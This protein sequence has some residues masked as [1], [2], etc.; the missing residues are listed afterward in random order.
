ME[1]QANKIA[2]NK[3]QGSPGG[4]LAK[5]LLVLGAAALLG[6]A[7]CCATNV[8]EQDYGRAYHNNIAQQVVNPRAALTETP[9][10]G[11][12]ANAAVNEMDRYNKTFKGEE[13]KG[14]EMKLTTPT[15]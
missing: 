13:K 14:L 15:Y 3:G 5:A 4:W 8:L 6:P 10:V 12:S 2:G 9:A 7:G 11:L 1:P